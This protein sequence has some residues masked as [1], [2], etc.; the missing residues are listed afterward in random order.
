MT[1]ESIFLLSDKDRAYFKRI[2]AAIFAELHAEGIDTDNDFSVEEDALQRIAQRL[3]ERTPKINPQATYKKA[4]KALKSHSF[5][6]ER[7][8]QETVSVEYYSRF[9]PDCP[10]DNET[11]AE[12]HAA[13]VAYIDALRARIESRDKSN[14][15]RGR[16]AYMNG[17][18]VVIY[19]KWIYQLSDKFAG[20][21]FVADSPEGI[22]D[23][24]AT[25]DPMYYI[26]PIFPE[27]EAYRILEQF[28]NGDPLY[29][30]Q[31]RK[32][33]YD[34]QPWAFDPSPETAEALRNA[35]G[36][37]GYQY[38]SREDYA[39][40]LFLDKYLKATV[41]ALPSV[42]LSRPRRG[43]GK[44]T[45][46]LFFS[47]P[48]G[49]VSNMILETLGA[50]AKLETLPESKRRVSRAQTIEIQTKGKARRIT[51]K[52]GKES[53]TVEY[54]DLDAIAGSNKTA[55]KMFVF[56]LMKA[57]EQALHNGQ[58][59][60]DYITFPLQEL[61]DIELYSTPQSARRGFN[62]GTDVLTSIK[63]KGHTRK[64]A[65][66]KGAGKEASVDA[67]E[68]L[69]TGARIVNGQCFIFLNDRID[70]RFIAQYFTILPRYC[71]KLGNK[72][73]DLLYYI[74]FLARQNTREIRERGYF[75][76]SFRAIQA[77]LQLPTDTKN[78][79]RDIKDRIDDALT[80]IELQHRD[81]YKNDEFQIEPVYDENAP[82]SDFL[83]RGY[84]KVILKGDFAQGFID[85]S[86]TA[87]KQI[88]QA[89]KKQA[90]IAEVAATAK[91]AAA[92]AKETE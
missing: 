11:D 79:L 77:R 69:F 48:E 47:V 83:D 4:H 27:T 2:R 90:R 71:F 80:D 58:L 60:R 68:V 24:L 65:T 28:D 7:W 86:T 31:G 35:L 34:P 14:P 62:A 81:I 37:S 41:D 55:K 43:L 88:D 66:K 45:E 23:A 38:I 70:W 74:F 29:K 61:I 51:V 46:T 3:K 1:D 16:F 89:A 82:I 72:S 20:K 18:T 15:Y 49:P 76:I 13:H 54:S 42:E 73:F 84:L 52:T 92:A 19:R 78:P 87:E 21:F 8:G 6:I 53:I 91:A 25:A 36:L 5:M 12:A 85:I 9:F 30:M 17:E 50:G 40:L 64:Y 67:N 57:N 22:E 26:F 32:M 75:T 59:T 39:T 44:R 10:P 63:I 33:V 56:A